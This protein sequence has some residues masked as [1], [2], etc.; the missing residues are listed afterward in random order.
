MIIK[1][2]GGREPF[3]R[4][5]L[6]R[7]ISQAIR[8]RPVSPL[9]VE[10]IINEIEDEAMMLAQTSREVPSH[11]LGEMVLSRLY[12]LD[13]VAYVRFASVYRNFE[14]VDEFV[15]EIESLNRAKRAKTVKRR[16]HR[17]NHEKREG[18]S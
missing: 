10:E 14:D 12:E 3:E 13:R 4:E 11:R 17:S 1:S 8:K 7:G 18:T 6:E 16:S 15:T 9:T 5:K 2:S